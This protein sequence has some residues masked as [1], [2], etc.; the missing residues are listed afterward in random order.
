MSVVT[1]TIT[2]PE[3]LAK[4]AAAEGP[5]LFRGPDGACVRWAEAMP[6]GQL[7]AGVRPPISPEAFEKLREQPDGR[8]LAEVWKRIHERHGS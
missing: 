7:P 6:Q 2:D 5:I 4:L 1:I 3:M 8:P